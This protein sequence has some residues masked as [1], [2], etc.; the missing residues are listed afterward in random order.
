MIPISLLVFTAG[1]GMEQTGR[2]VMY[3]MPLWLPIFS[4]QILYFVK[5]KRQ[6]G[7]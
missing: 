2:Y 7:K 4:Q 5:N 1:G 3:S 6:D